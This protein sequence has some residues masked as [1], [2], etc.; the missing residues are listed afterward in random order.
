MCGLRSKLV[1]L[2]GL[3]SLSKALGYYE[4]CHFLVNYEFVMFYGTDPWK[5]VFNL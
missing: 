2:Y 4:I 1:C 5:R 3:V